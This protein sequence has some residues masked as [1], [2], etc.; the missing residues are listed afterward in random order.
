VRPAE[1]KIE[2]YNYELPEERIAK[3]PLP[4]RDESKLLYLNNNIPE[5]RKFRELPDL[6]SSD[7]LLVFN[8]TKVIRARLLF[9][10]PSGAAIEI[11]CLEPVEPTND[12]QLA[13]QQP[14]T[15]VWKCLVGNARRWKNEILELK[16]GNGNK[17]IVLKAEKKSK[18]GNAFLIAFNWKPENLPF[19]EI[20]GQT[21]QVPLPP[22]LNRKAEESDKE[23][24]QTIYARQ[25]GS[26]AA[27]TAGLHFTD[28]IFEK[29]HTK[30][31]ETEQVTLHVGAGTFKPVS[32]ET[33]AG[34]EMHTEHIV[35]PVEA[36]KHMRKKI[37][38]RIIAVGT[39]S[40]RT[41]ESLY[42]MAAKLRSGDDS[43][44]INQW[45]PYDLEQEISGREALEILIDYAAS[46]GLKEIKGQ[47][48]MIIAPGYHLKMARGLLTNFHQPKSTLLLLVAAIIGDRWKNAY[49][50]S[51]QNGFRFLSYGDSCLFLY[52]Q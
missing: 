26:V 22:Y 14:S 31:I 8:E 21:G 19:A 9:R 44:K 47:T 13:F 41:I 5:A 29:L 15:V 32:S 49:D 11:F 37:E 46:N 18:E 30:G 42:W 52:E 1:I 6:L 10:K 36:L 35:V 2:D 40:L 4:Q 12:F 45:D 17:T 7:S 27:P 3:Y 23:R 51:L 20:I 43:F 25:D 48:Q 38:D 34:H 28:R 24:Y 16:I 39:T 33:M 50:F